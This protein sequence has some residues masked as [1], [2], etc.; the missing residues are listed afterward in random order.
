MNIGLIGYG[1]VGRAVEG[2]FKDKCKVYVYDPKFPERSEASVEELISKVDFVFIGVPTPMLDVYGGPS[3]TSI[4]DT[5]MTEVNAACNKL[6][7]FPIV[8]VKSAIL[9]SRLADYAKFFPLLKLVKSPEYLTDKNSMEDFVNAELLVLGGKREYTDQVA[10][11]FEEFSTC[12]PCKVGH[13]DLIAAGFLKYMENCYLSMK[14]IFMNQFYEV[15][16]RSG[17][18][19]TWE[20]VA[21][22]FHYDSRMGN[23]HYRVPGPDGDFG[24]GGKCVLPDSEVKIKEFSTDEYIFGD[25]GERKISIKELFDLSE[26]RGSTMLLQI[27]SC[28][29]N[30]NSIEYKE[31]K[32]VTRREVDEHI[33]VFDTD[34]GKFKCTAEHLMPVI[35]NGE[36]IIVM[37]K[38]IEESDNLLSK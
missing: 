13:C 9:P 33:Y 10:K 14:V 29:S 24:F 20:E 4:M 28:N 22:I 25:Y 32:A 15:L 18:E 5:V 2:G 27:E 11:L 30:I 8:I 12:K 1:I 21:E 7:K 35:R 17:S 34:Q 6:G 23:S 37:A 16:K 38:D 3:D 31:I 36:K 19:S 26:E